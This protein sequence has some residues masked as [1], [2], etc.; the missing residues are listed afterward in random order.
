MVDPDADSPFNSEIHHGSIRTSFIFAFDIYLYVVPKIW[1]I[2]EL[3]QVSGLSVPPARS[4]IE[5]TRAPSK[6]ELQYWFYPYTYSPL[7]S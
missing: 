6:I 3:D 4:S 1:L 2:F 7:I 5:L